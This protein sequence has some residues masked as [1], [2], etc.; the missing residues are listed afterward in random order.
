MS[1]HWAAL[2]VP[3]VIAR[4]AMAATMA[5]LTFIAVRFNFLPFSRLGATIHRPYRAF[6]YKI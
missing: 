1:F 4:A 5:A 6:V 2:A 3:G